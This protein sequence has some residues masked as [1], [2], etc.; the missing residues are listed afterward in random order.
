[1]VKPLEQIK[2][3][4]PSRG[5]M[6][7]FR[8]DKSISFSCFRCGQ[9]KIS[10]LITIYNNDW[11]KRLCNGCYGRLLSIY[12]IKSGQIDIDEKVERLSSLL[13][14]LFDDNKIR[15]QSHRL[16]IRQ[17]KTK[18]LSSSSLKFYAT[19]ECVAETLAKE[20]NLDWS[21]AIIGLC[22]AFEIEI[23]E[24]FINPLKEFCSNI[25]ITETDLKDKDF[26]RVASYCFGKTMKS[27]ELG[28]ISHFI[29][30]AVNSKARFE[31]SDFLKTGFKEFISKR[32]NSNWLIDKNCLVSAI[33]TLTHNYRN[34]AAHT[35]EL[36]QI[37]YNN[38]REFVFGDKG[39]MWDLIVSTQTV[40]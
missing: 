14:K 5:P 4:Y 15:E 21:A 9:N 27:P 1:M 36:E 6:Q 2:K 40:K 20:F 33:D 19:S 18:L 34:K 29:S 39:I 25:Q 38:C 8:F 32:P 22:K 3:E 24:R 7:Q 16:F 12:D 11:N 23:I 31:K 17:N 10:K 30:T 26:G 28:V 13:L 35:D 37:D